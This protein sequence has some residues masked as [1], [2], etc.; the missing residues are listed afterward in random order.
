MTTQ[1][2]KKLEPQE[3]ITRRHVGDLSLTPGK[4]NGCWRCY[5]NTMGRPSREANNLSQEYHA[6]KC[7]VHLREVTFAVPPW[8]G[9]IGDQGKGSYSH[10]ANFPPTSGTP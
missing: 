1:D 7:P 2:M 3:I 6:K 8:D 4:K 10:R 5:T 9:G